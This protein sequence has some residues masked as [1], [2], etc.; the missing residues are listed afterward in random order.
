MLCTCLHFPPHRLVLSVII[1]QRELSL[2]KHLILDS[3]S[4][5]HRW[6]V[7]KWSLSVRLLLSLRVDNRNQKQNTLVTSWPLDAQELLPKTPRALS[8]TSRLHCSELVF[9][10]PELCSAVEF[11]EKKAGSPGPWTVSSCTA[12][13]SFRCVRS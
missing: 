6:E 11:R 12:E 4:G 1:E 5:F 10:Q 7:S 3:S 13:D 8:V 2:W 9:S